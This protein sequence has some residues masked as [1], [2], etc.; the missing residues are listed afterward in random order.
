MSSEKYKMLGN[1]S[2]RIIHGDCIEALKA[3]D[4]N[5]IDLIFAD[6]PYN[7]GKNFDGFIDRWNNEED[8]LSWC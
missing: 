4:D 8:Y 5:S 2:H 7:I 6:P 1:S 3:I